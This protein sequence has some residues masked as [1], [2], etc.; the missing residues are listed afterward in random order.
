MGVINYLLQGASLPLGP[1]A[2]T[3]FDIIQSGGSN[4]ILSEDGNLSVYNY[5]NGFLSSLSGGGVSI[6]NDLND[7]VVSVT[8]NTGFDI[9]EA[10]GKFHRFDSEG[11]KLYDPINGSINIYQGA[12]YLGE[13]GTNNSWKIIRSGNNL[14]FQRYISGS[15]VTKSTIAG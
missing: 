13:A 14:L 10:S 5:D 11:I 2:E 4:R 3:G 7:P 1:Y 8:V 15:Y 9:T 6:S 12:Y